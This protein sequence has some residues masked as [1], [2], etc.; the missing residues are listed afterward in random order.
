ME[1]FE[2][3]NNGTHDFP[4]CVYNISSEHGFEVVP[5]VHGEFE[6][7][8]LIKGSGTLYV[9][10]APYEIKAGECAF[11]N[12]RELHLGT[13]ENEDS[14]RFFAVVFSKQMIGGFGDDLIMNRYVLPVEKGRAV[15]HRILRPDIDWQEKVLRL[16]MQ[17]READEK[18]EQG[19]ELC[20][21]AL[22]TEVWRL[23]FTHSDKQS[24]HSDIGIENIKKSLEFI[25]SEYHQPLTLE[26]MAA[27]AG[28]SR[29]YF[30]R[31]F[32]DVLRMTPFEYLMQIRVE[33]AC[34]LLL[35][36]ELSIGEIAERSGF[37]SFSYFS[38]VFRRIMRCSPREYKHNSN[39]SPIDKT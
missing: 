10:G 33:Q 12:S 22:L 11:I 23:C 38:K 3:L 18:R 30:C 1:Y 32:A 39:I 7:L 5:H 15:F 34:R 17:L 4:V 29:G 14:V 13:S 27:N 26:Q 2:W 37:N 28:M 24:A 16:L 20:I 19:Y 6:F 21:K 35:T 25:R 9:D 31:Y 8:M 36:T